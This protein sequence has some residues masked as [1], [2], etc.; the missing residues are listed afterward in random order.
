MFLSSVLEANKIL[1]RDIFK[2]KKY[3][4]IKQLQRVDLEYTKMYVLYVL[5]FDACHMYNSLMLGL[6][7]VWFSD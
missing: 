2:H 4:I 3:I 1:K 7:F 5:K 6:L